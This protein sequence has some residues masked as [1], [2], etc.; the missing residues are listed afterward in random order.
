MLAQ[1]TRQLAAF[2]VQV[3]VHRFARGN[4]FSPRIAQ[5]PLAMQVTGVDSLTIR[6]PQGQFPS[7][8]DSYGF[9]AIDTGECSH[10]AILFQGAGVEVSSLMIPSPV[11]AE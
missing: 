5:G 7:P 9:V 2:F 8:V 11:A 4:P 3:D 1:D 10:D 6:A